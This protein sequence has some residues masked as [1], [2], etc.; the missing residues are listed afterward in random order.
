MKEVLQQILQD[1]LLE[2]MFWG[3]DGSKRM[4]KLSVDRMGEI[5]T[6]NLNGQREQ[7]LEKMIAQYSLL[8][9]E[10]V[11]VKEQHQKLL[12]KHKQLQKSLKKSLLQSETQVQVLSSK[13]DQ[14]K[15]QYEEEKHKEEENFWS[16]INQ[17]KH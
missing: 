9:K 1:E 13:L 15:C 7:F 14:E 4:I 6:E 16:R 2:E 5:L 8:K 12:S 11:Q 3:Q 17:L 10:F